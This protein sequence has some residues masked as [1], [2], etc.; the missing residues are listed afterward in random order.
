MTAFNER[1]CN[2]EGQ[3][4]PI[5]TISFFAASNEI[6]DF[7]EKKILEALYD[8]LDLKLVTKYIMDPATRLDILRRKE[9]GTG[10][11][12]T[13][14]ITLDELLEMQ[15]EVAQVVIPTELNEIMD[16]VLMDLRSK[17]VIVTD[18]TYL[19]YY[20]MVRAMA[21]LRGA[22]TAAPA[23][24]MILRHCLWKL[25][26]ERAAVT[27]SLT[28]LCVSP[29]LERI[30]EIHQLGLDALDSC[31]N[32][33]ANTQPSRRMRKFL[34]EIARV[35]DEYVKVAQEAQ[36][37]DEVAQANS[38]NYELEEMSKKAHNACGYSWVPMDEI[39]SLRSA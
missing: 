17:K 4:I 15:Q 7:N 8:R 14:T 12:I 6:P 23:D 39:Y 29:V 26:E 22:G 10:E 27:E 37:D 13:A 28:R 3:T 5:P 16:K 20:R 1:V 11:N 31:M 18:R 9:D 34:A 36:T 35:Y 38:L 33:D 2:N 19:G 24:M 25:P 32:A 21:W 30:K